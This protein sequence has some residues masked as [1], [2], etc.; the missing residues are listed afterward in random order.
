VTQRNV[1]G[2]KER[3]THNTHE[4]Y[5]NDRHNSVRY[6]NHGTVF[7]A[8]WRLII[9]QARTAHS[10]PGKRQDMP[11]SSQ[12]VFHK[13]PSLTATQ[14][15]TSALPAASSTSQQ[16]GPYALNI[17]QGASPCQTGSADPLSRI[18]TST[19]IIVTMG[20]PL[21]KRHNMHPCRQNQIGHGFRNPERLKSGPNHQGVVHRT[22]TM[23]RTTP[24]LWR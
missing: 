11:H 21:N 12:A 5:N 23:R 6:L 17:H 18:A 9:S 7:T 20:L 16:A 24:L 8:F 14:T 15:T 4:S 19:P 1:L 13:T 2:F 22:E 10:R 3:K